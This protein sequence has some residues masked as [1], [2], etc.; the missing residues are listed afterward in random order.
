MSDKTAALIV[1]ICAIVTIYLAMAS[2]SKYDPSN[3]VKLVP[4]E[5]WTK[6]L[7][8][9]FLYKE[10]G[11]WVEYQ[12][13]R[14]T[15]KT[16]LYYIITRPPKDWYGPDLFP[17]NGGPPWYV[18]CGHNNP[19]CPKQYWGKWEWFDRLELEDEDRQGLR[20]AAEQ[21]ANIYTSGYTSGR[22]ELIKELTIG[23]HK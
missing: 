15:D 6:E 10:R 8:S 18:Y 12:Y 3:I 7:S 4:R 20:R 17:E 13:D 14:K 22:D 9:F 16:V 11:Y 19:H 21:A 23:D 2:I 1:I 5:E